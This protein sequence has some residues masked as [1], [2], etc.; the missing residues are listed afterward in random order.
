MSRPLV[1]IILIVVLLALAIFIHYQ[2]LDRRKFIA[3]LHYV[4]HL[5][6]P[7]SDWLDKALLVKELVGVEYGG[8]MPNLESSVERYNGIKNRKAEQK[9]EV[10][11]DAYKALK[12][13]V[14]RNPEHP[15]LLQWQKQMNGA[16]DE[17]LETVNEYNFYARRYNKK[18][19]TRA[20]ALIRDLLHLKY[21]TVLEDL[22][23]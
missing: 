16:Y 18:L 22:R 21:L 5:D 14:A 3:V 2:M 19:D 20:G 15:G 23:L 4:S 11:N 13:I 6:E 1:G 8:N 12:A 10:V 7:V 17:F 9:P